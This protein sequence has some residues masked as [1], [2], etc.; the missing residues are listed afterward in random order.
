MPHALHLSPET[1][2]L[3]KKLAEAKGQPLAAVVREAIEASAREAGIAIPQPRAINAAEK[4]RRMREI[5]DRSAA[6]P[7]LDPRA[8]E[9]IIGYDDRGLPR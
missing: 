6:R 7:V 9:E 2:A 5:S 4:F 3:A 8:P 1:E